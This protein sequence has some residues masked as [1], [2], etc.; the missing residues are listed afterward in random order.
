MVTKSKPRTYN[1]KEVIFTVGDII[2]LENGWRGSVIGIFSGEALLF[3]DQAFKAV[4]GHSA[5]PNGNGKKNGH[6][7]LTGQNPFGIK[8]AHIGKPFKIRW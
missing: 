2:T 8:I 4:M 5:I 6:W 3:S 7:Y 1:G